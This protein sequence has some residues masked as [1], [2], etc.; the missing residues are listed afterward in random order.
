MNKM[1][2]CQIHNATSSQ[3]KIT[4]VMLDYPG[5]IQKEV[6]QVVEVQM[7]CCGVVR[8]A[9][10]VDFKPELINQ[11]KHWTEVKMQ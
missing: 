10:C 7:P 11:V 9:E 1:N 5:G 6:S 8:R 4:P 3:I 2:Q